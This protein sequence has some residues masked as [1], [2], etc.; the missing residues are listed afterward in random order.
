MEQKLGSSSDDVLKKPL[1]GGY[2]PSTER[3]RDLDL[4]DKIPGWGIDLDPAVRPGVPRDQARLIGSDQL[5]PAFEQQVPRFKIFKSTE[6][7]RLTPVFGTSCPPSG[8]SGLIRAQAYKLSEGRV[9]HWLMLVTA[10]RINVI[11]GLLEDFMHL[12]IPNIP[13]EMGWKADFKYNKK[14]IAKAFFTI[15]GVALSALALSKFLDDRRKSKPN[16]D[17]VVVDEEISVDYPTAGDSRAS[18]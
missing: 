1:Q 16:F 13:K 11:E 14:G 15:G 4:S 10:D 9:Q 7:A 2:N 17:Y 8:L 3:R 12:R 5:Y 6:H 18:F